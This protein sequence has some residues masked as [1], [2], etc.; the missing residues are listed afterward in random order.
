M[1]ILKPLI[2]W[3]GQLTPLNKNGIE[4]IA[5]H[6][7]AHPSWTFE[8]VHRGHLNRGWI[9]IGYNF[10]VGFDGK[11][12]EG[13]G[14]NMGAGVKGENHTIL[15][16]GFQGNFEIQTMPEAQ[17]NAGVELIKWLQT[18][19][20]KARIIHGHKYWATTA[21]PGKN[22]P[23]LEMIKAIEQPPKEVENMVKVVL[24]GKEIGEGKLINGTTYL[25]VRAL[26]EA[27]NLAVAWNAKTKT[28]SIAKK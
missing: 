27:L 2:N 8:E 19:L 11:V 15:S 20:P 23:L 13:R 4:G 24:E 26:A 16:I 22:F 7:M 6:H 12:Y 28:V 25:P 10:W 14:F 1:N 9:G 5:L 18:Q 3:K 17:F 21:C